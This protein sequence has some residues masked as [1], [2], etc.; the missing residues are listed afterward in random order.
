MRVRFG[1]PTCDWRRH[2]RTPA[3]FSSAEMR[4]GRQW[5]C[6]A[7]VS[8]SC[9]VKGEAGLDQKDTEKRL[10]GLGKAHGPCLPAAHHERSG[11][12]T[13]RGGTILRRDG[14][15]RHRSLRYSAGRRPG[16]RDIAARRAGMLLRRK[17][18]G[19]S[20]V[21]FSHHGAACRAMQLRGRWHL[22]ADASHHGERRH[23]EDD[24]YQKCGGEFETAGHNVN[25]WCAHQ[26]AT[27]SDSR[28]KP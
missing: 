22:S 19:R 18:H 6:R 5:P 25:G 2:E 9:S 23:G 13:R 3:E 26:R 1:F 21:R 27:I 15:T 4:G 16:V 28:H 20:G 7:Q 14:D 24:Q 11:H 12:K 10:R 8:E 17:L